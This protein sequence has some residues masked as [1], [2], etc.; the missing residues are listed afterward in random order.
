MTAS[1][2]VA[3][4][5]GTD[6][7]YVYCVAHSRAHWLLG[8][9]GLDRNMVYTVPHEG[10]CC[11]VHSCK[12][13]PYQSD[14]PQAVEGWVVAHQRVVKTA[15]EAFDAALPMAF[16]M[17][18][19]DGPN[20]SAIHSLKGWLAEKRDDFSA[21]LEELAGKAEYGVQVFWDRQAVIEALTERQPELRD[22]RDEARAK[23]K[24][25]AYMLRQRLAKAARAAIES[26]ANQYVEA[27]YSQIGQCVAKA[28]VERLKRVN[29]GK[30]MLL[31]LSCLMEKDN[32]AL[33]RAL[34]KIRE[35]D[36][37]SVR[38]TGPWPPYSFVSAA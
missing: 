36:G 24:G 38:F 13:K 14:D 11:V 7:V 34:E 29:S 23:P 30:Q 10:L 21:R 8:P 37:I 2:T 12:A 15:M 16:N 17:I 22:L 19:H 1:P 35:I 25:Q 6:A 32:T 33:G 31:N 3:D 5:I 26:Q 20:G 9:I 4:T 28:R 27:F 18:V